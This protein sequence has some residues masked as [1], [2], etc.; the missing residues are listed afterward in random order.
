MYLDYDEYGL[1][2]ALYKLCAQLK[3]GYVREPHH[4]EIVLDFTGADYIDRNRSIENCSVKVTALR[5]RIRDDLYSVTIMM[6]NDGSQKGS[7]A[8]C[9]LQPEIAIATENNTFVFQD[10]SGAE[11]YDI[12]TDEEKSLE[13]Q[14]RNNHVYGSGLGVAVAWDISPDGHGVLKFAAVSMSR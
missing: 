3:S 13:L 12:L 10:Y 1:F 5:R 4:A 2:D 11:N 14:Y 8:D 6:V 7:G 9:I